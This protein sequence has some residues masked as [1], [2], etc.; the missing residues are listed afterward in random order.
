ML[1]KLIKWP[2]VGSFRVKWRNPLNEEEK[3]EWQEIVVKSRSGGIIKGLFANARTAAKATIVLGHPMGKEA[4]AFFLKNGYTDLLR[5]NGYNTLVFD[6]NG[7]GEST[8]G[9]F[10]YFEDVLAVAAKA[11]ELT[12]ELPIGYH[13]I[14]LGG[15][16]AII[17]FADQSHPFSFSIIESAPA[18]P[19]EF[20]VKYPSA[21]RIYRIISFFLP[22]YAKKIRPVDR[23]RDLKNQRS[24]LLIYSYADEWTPVSMGERLKEN[25]PVP[26]E[27]WTV[28]HAAHTGIMK[29][30]HKE[31]YS[32]KIISYFDEAV[33]RL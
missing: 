25:S 22:R 6:F 16:W 15:Q 8:N 21:F 30:E 24:L 4:K 26:T 33:N 28:Q 32:K 17:S 31:G 23:I 13:G 3:K 19:E 14:S 29:S 9:S 27:L 20:W 12:P 7:F 11:R 18:T 10:S 1:Y 2:F 5:D